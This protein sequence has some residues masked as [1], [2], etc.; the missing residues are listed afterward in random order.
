MSYRKYKNQ[1]YRREGFDLKCDYGKGFVTTP[2]FYCGEPA[3]SEDHVFPLVALDSL[4]C[5]GS[6]PKGSDVL[7]IVPS[8]LE[9]NS[10]A[11]DKVFNTREEKKR[12]IQRRLQN[13]YRDVLHQEVWDDDELAEM[14]GDLHRW[15]TQSEVE[16][17]RVQSRIGYFKVLSLRRKK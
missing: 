3:A 5:E 7:T 10:L 16:R 2:C 8:C 6:A 13:R 15:I 4:L 1:F 14:H 12:Y 11:G 17:R 9:C